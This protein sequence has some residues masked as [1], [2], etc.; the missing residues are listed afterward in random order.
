MTH[1]RDV[2]IVQPKLLSFLAV[3]GLLGCTS[4]VVGT[5][6]A[7][8]MVP[9]HDW[10]ADTI[11]DLAA[12]RWEIVMDV[13][14]YGFAAGLMATSLA[15]AHVHPGGTGW[16][17]GVVAFAVL[18]AVVTIVAARNEYGDNDSEGVVIHIYLVYALGLLFA[19]APLSMASG[20]TLYAGWARRALIGLAVLWVIAA[21]IFFFLPTDVD[22]LYERLLG[23]IGCGMVVVLCLSFLGHARSIARD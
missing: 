1:R 15:A 14:L 19:V 4:L 9:G 5:F 17:V 18:A 2:L 22:G 11:S 21:P 8:Q 20:V 16:S 12:G 3:L 10:I 23:L 13:A 7:Q 6:V